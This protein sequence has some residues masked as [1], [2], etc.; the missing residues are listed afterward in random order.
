MEN[1]SNKHSL[2]QKT[3]VEFQLETEMLRGGLNTPYI[4]EILEPLSQWGSIEAASNERKLLVHAGNAHPRTAQFSTEYFNENRMKSAPHPPYSPDRAL[5]DFY[6]YGH[7]LSE[8]FDQ[9]EPIN[10][11]K[12]YCNFESER[13]DMTIKI[14]T[15]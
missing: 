6:L 9:R 5:S 12:R 14:F 13:F 3:S 1:M 7:G 11:V 2:I 8:F 15:I 10:Q 4:P